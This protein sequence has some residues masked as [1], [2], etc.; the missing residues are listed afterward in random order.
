MFSGRGIVAKILVIDDEPNV[1]TLLDVLLR[2]QGY[3]VVLAE[4]GRKGLE[5]YSREHPDV[6]ILDL[7][8]PELD[9]VTVLKQIRNVDLTQPVIIL[10]GDSTPE[11]ERQ[12][13]A[14]GVSEF[15]VKGSSLHLLVDTLT[16]LLKTPAPP[17]VVQQ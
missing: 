3:D 7:K 14:L 17:M 2:L 16:R 12:V 10:T 4:N 13:R 15:I 11:T 6:I 5:F 9:G 8:M 1:R